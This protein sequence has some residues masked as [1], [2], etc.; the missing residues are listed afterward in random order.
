MTS[1]SRTALLPYSAEEMYDLVADVESYPQFLPWCGGTRV[2]ARDCQQVVASIDVAYRGIRRSFS[3]RNRLNQ[4]RSLEMD[5]LEGPF[6]HFHGCWRFE[7]I[8]TRG[9]KI[10]LDLE[11]DFSNRVLALALEPVFTQI[12]KS[13]MDS[14]KKR[15]MAV[16]GARI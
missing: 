14:F 7:P 16:Y 2:I 4:G 15:A 8:D 13:L 6:R 3:T 11:F 5:L 12:A 1:I 9:S 10:S